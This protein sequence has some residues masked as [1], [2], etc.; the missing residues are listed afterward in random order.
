MEKVISGRG[1]KV[2][3]M[4]PH[5]SFVICLM[6]KKY[7]PVP[8]HPFLTATVIV[9]T[10]QKKTSFW[11]GMKC[12][13]ATWFAKYIHQLQNAFMIFINLHQLAFIA[14]RTILDN[15]S[16]FDTYIQPKF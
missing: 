15:P 7:N 13:F 16:S 12:M 11:L 6:S 14:K 5:M 10:L 4:D 9:H 8:Q 1:S 3:K 2:N